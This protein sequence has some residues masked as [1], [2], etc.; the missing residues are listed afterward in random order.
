MEDQLKSIFSFLKKNRIYNKEFQTRFYL[1]VIQSQNNKFEKII[2]LLYQIANTQSQPKIDNLAA[3]YKKIY[4][5]EN[6]LNS[7]ESF[8]KLL[9]PESD[10]KINY[11]SLYFG[12]K[13]QIGWGEK[14]AAL[15][16]KT[17]YHLHNAEYPNNLKI[18]NDAPIE[19]KKD[20]LFYL[21]VDAVIISIFN[22]LENKN[23]TFGKVNR[24]IEKY[25]SGDD[26]EIWD[27]L[28]FWGFITQIGTGNE[29]KM[30]WNLNKYW[31]LR[32]SDKN[33]LIIGEIKSKAEEFLNILRENKQSKIVN[34]KS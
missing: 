29:R 2:S 10:I 30:K 19:L 32:E 7:F 24:E 23:W 12:M 22:F 1:S 15:F 27:D 11:R 5:N 31:T 14:T 9:N 20:D 21:P 28:W 26:I 25:Y 33:P 17:I 4:T 16:T 3:F 18:W 13:N 6:H 8:V 34:L